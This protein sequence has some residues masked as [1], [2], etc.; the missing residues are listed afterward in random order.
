MKEILSINC[1]ST[2][3]GGSYIWMAGVNIGNQQSID[4]NPSLSTSYIVEYI[5]NGCSDFDTT[6]VTVNMIPWF[7]LMM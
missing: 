3:T 6:L 5:I 2:T 1:Y 4:V 7:K